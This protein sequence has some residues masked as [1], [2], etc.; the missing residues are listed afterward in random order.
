METLRQAERASLCAPAA[1]G[2]DIR[3]RMRLPSFILFNHI[4]ILGIRG[5]IKNS[6]SLN[7]MSVTGPRFIKAM[8]LAEIK[9]THHALP[10][11][12]TIGIEGQ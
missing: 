6:H 10:P 1:G 3:I 5:L 4:K 12:G 7:E 8:A 11:L 2:G 9:E